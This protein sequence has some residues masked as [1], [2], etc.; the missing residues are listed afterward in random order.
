MIYCIIFLRTKF[1]FTFFQG[2]EKPAMTWA[3]E[4]R[5]ICPCSLKDPGCILSLPTLPT[6]ILVP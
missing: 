2:L 1:Y 4:I 5:G 6:H 3:P